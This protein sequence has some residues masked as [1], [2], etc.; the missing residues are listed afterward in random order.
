MAQVLKGDGGG[1]KLTADV[2]I[3]CRKSVGLADAR[4]SDM[5]RF[6]LSDLAATFLFFLV[7][8]LTFGVWF[9]V[10]C[11]F[12]P[13][14]VFC[15]LHHRAISHPLLFHSN[16]EVR[17]VASRQDT[18]L[19]VSVVERLLTLLSFTVRARGV[20]GSVETLGR[21]T[22]CQQIVRHDELDD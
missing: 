7:T 17:L 22:P 13:F 19:S 11:F 5:F 9:P 1:E 16:G 20:T 3:A 12:L 15:L 10:L 21:S 18:V 6:D 14:Y 2:F 4:R 8:L